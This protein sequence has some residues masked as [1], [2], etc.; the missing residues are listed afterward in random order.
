MVAQY[1]SNATFLYPIMLGTFNPALELKAAGMDLVRE[2]HYQV[3]V[4]LEGMPLKTIGVFIIVAAFLRERTPGRPLW[5]FLL[6]CLGG[7]TMLVHGLTQ[8]DAGNIGRYALGFLLAFVLA[9]ALV[10][11]TARLGSGVVRLGRPHVAAGLALFAMLAQLVDSRT[12]LYKQYQRWFANIDELS[13]V[14]ARSFMT[15]PPELKIYEH[16]QGSVPEGARIAI[17]LDEPYLLDFRRNPIW[18]LDMPGYSSLPPGMPFFRGKGELEAY[19]KS[20]GIRYLAFVRPEY[21]RYHYRREYWVEMVANEQE[22]WRAF[23]P[24]LL[25]FLDNEV[26]I[27]AGHKRLFEERG[28]VVIDMQEP[29]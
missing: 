18:N 26:A 22:I 25:D 23:A 10:A 7:T 12:A 2:L 24:Y 8:S 13:V 6:G 14:P 1:Q 20:V 29:P 16:L 4:A 27:A 3:W 9:A 28:L 17:L 19:L 11:G 15:E 21:S 5:S